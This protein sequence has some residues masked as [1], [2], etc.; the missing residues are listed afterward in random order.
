MII[1]TKVTLSLDKDKWTKFRIE[2]LKRGVS[3]SNVIEKMI[4]EKLKEKK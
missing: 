2:C 3:A 4:E 1:K